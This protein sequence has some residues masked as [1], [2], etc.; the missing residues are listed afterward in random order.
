MVS[1]REP[2]TLRAL[3]DQTGVSTMA[4]YTYFDGMSGLWRAVRQEG[5]TR[6]AARLD[7]VRRTGD[8]VRDFVALGAAY[9]AN[10]LDGPALYRVMFDAQF[11]LEDPVA[12]DAAFGT[13]VA[14]AER[15]RSSGRLRAD[16]DPLDVATRFWAFGHGIVMLVISGVLPADALA[17]HVPPTTV[18]MLLAAGDHDPECTRSVRNG[19]RTLRLA[20]A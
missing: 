19:W 4:V 1:R 8:P 14:A 7:G 11:E 6:L 17:A 20:G 5:F 16:V 3:V 9:T 13:L 18:A 2:V 12:A 10:A 15:A